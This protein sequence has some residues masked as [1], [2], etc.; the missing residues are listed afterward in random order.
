MTYR[1]IDQI[2]ARGYFA[3]RKYKHVTPKVGSQIKVY[4]KL[5]A[6]IKLLWLCLSV[7]VF[8]LIEKLKLWMQMHGV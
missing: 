7:L 8:N 6:Y 1:Q 4:F 2:G 5:Y 3:F